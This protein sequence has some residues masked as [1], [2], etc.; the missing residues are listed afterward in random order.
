[1]GFIMAL[2]GALGAI[3]RHLVDRGLRN[4]LGHWTIAVINV[5][6]SFVLGLSVGIAF[7]P[8]GRHWPDFVVVG[9]CGGFTTLSTASVE[10]AQHLGRRAWSCAITTVA[11]MAALACAGLWV[12]RQVGL[13]A[14][15]L[16]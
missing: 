6:G 5:V 14:Q 3:A 1:M 15:L 11:V 12:G 4:R 10:A 13:L 2:C 8:V 9:F 7:T 16:A